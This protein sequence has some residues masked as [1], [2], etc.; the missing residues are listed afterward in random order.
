MFREIEW[1]RRLELKYI[2]VFASFTNFLKKFQV[3]IG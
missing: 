1:G 2:N 3:E